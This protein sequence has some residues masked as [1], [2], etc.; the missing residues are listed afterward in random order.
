[1]RELARRPDKDRRDLFRATAQRMRIHEAMVEK[2]FWVCWALD[3]L[4]Q[5]SPW[6]DD[7]AFTG[8]TSLSK[9]FAAI[10]RFS[11]DIDLI[12]DWRLLGYALDEPWEER[13]VTRQ[14]AF[15][16]ESNRR[17]VDFLASV[18]VP[19]VRGSLADRLGAAMKVEAREQEV[20]IHYPAA[21]SL[22]AIQPQI[23]LELGPMAAWAPNEPRAIHP[24]AAEQFPE[25]FR[26]RETS[27]RTIAAERAF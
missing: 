11:E 23:R 3:Y 26:Q 2:D 16:K 12:L 27:V 7:L 8:G 17:T 21:F 6:K 19:A 13:S 10:E 1:M 24:Y 25:Q 14:D 5:D 18:F 4:F 15:G 22:A 20:L 9:A